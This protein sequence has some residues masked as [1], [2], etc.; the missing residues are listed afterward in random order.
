MF[1]NQL[2]KILTRLSRSRNYSDSDSLWI[3]FISSSSLWPEVLWYSRSHP[4]SFLTPEQRQTRFFPVPFN[5]EYRRLVFLL[6]FLNLGFPGASVVKNPS[7]TVKDVGSITG[8]GRS[9][10]EG[11]SNPLLYS[12]LRNP[13]DRGTWQTI[14]HGVAKKSWA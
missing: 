12:C 3:L 8:S 4:G 9:L 10:G 14:V 5:W 7:A 1:A 11:N 2:K 6:L 13:M